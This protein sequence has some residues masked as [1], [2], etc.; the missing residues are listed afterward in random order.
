MKEAILVYTDYHCPLN[1]PPEREYYSHG[2][3]ASGAYFETG[4][5]KSASESRFEAT[6]L[7]SD[8][9]ELRFVHDEEA[10]R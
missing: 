5:H 7:I 9:Y 4:W 8:K 6:E 2:K 10:G 3:T 1:L